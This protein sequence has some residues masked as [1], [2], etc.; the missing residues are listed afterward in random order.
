[1]KTYRHNGEAWFCD[2]RSFFTR[3]RQWLI[4]F[5][6]WEKARGGWSFFLRMSYYR[7]PWW[8]RWHLKSPAPLSMLGHR[9]TYYG[10]G[11]QFRLSNGW[12]VIVWRPSFEKG[13]YISK[14]GT[15]DAAHHWISGTPKSVLKAA[16][17]HQQQIKKLDDYYEQKARPSDS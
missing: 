4:W 17:D 13:I 16:E 1:M 8:K 11:C 2:D 10:W 12:L 14:D 5:G 9:F 6:G 15:P 7:S 3:F